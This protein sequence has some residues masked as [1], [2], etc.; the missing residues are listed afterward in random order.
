MFH[1]L[2][3]KALH[4]WDESL[5]ATRAFYL[6]HHGQYFTNWNQVDHCQLPHPNTK[7][8]LAGL[9]QAISFNTIGYTRLAL[10]LPVA[11]MGVLI[12]I[13]LVYWVRHAKLGVFTAF[14]AGIILLANEGFNAQHILRSG[15]H[16]VP[17]TFW[18]ILSVYSAF[19]YGVSKNQKAWAILIFVF[20]AL[21]VLTKSIMGL[22]LLPAIAIYLIIVHK[23]KVIL[24]QK[25]F[26][27]GI[28]V[29]I[30]SVSSFYLIMDYIHAGF[31]QL[32]WDNE[33]G[34]RYAKTI[35]NHKEVWHYYIDFLFKKGFTP[36]IW[37]SIGGIFFGLFSKSLTLKRL[38]LLLSIT[39]AFYLFV[40]SSAQTKLLWYAA[41]LYPLLSIL[42]AI[43]I[44][45]LWLIIKNATGK[46]IQKQIAFTIAQVA[47]ALL[48]VGF[49]AAKI[50][51]YNAT[52]KT[53]YKVERYEI[54][55]EK[56]RLKYPDYKNIKILSRD[57]WYPGLVFIANKYEKLYGYNIEL[58]NSKS[59]FST[60]DII[61]S[62]YNKRFE[63]L[64][65]KQLGN[66]YDGIKLY[67]ILEIKE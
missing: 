27:I 65:L 54:D 23:P 8:P 5:F 19:Q 62:E 46:I 4:T 9:I 13:L 57:E 66:F 29:L 7:P 25:A 32:V 34:G 2:D 63:K 36:Y 35:D 18:L 56:L 41:P 24:K 58:A 10:R 21:A 60:G 14:L 30:T 45:G 6:A 17:L 53:T 1:R 31:L 38:T 40:I 51:R 64:H 43:G 33:V 42:A 61:F 47:I 11:I 52:A 16:D 12:S 44:N 20:T 55:F 59:T 48:I 26:Y 28:L 39:A 50:I 37:F 22:M 67:Q 15:D 3:A 49:V